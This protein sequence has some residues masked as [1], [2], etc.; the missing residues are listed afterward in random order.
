MKNYK[1]NFQVSV[2][3]ILISIVTGSFFGIDK[4]TSENPGDE[5]SIYIGLSDKDSS[6]CDICMPGGIL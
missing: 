1:I 4:F 3:L 2:I 6:S 5:A